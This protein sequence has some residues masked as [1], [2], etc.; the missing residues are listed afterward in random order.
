[1]RARAWASRK[2]SRAA[3]G[4]LPPARPRAMRAGVW[5][6]RCA[7]GA[8]A[9]AGEDEGDEAGV[10]AWGRSVLARDGLGEELKIKIKDRLQA[11]SYEEDAGCR[12]I[13]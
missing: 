10:M 3:V 12:L 4:R 9:T 6:R 5:R 1:M 7:Q 11:G 8:G 13:R 2:S